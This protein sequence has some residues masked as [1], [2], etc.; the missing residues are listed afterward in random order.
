M[1]TS[2][3]SRAWIDDP[4]VSVS[5]DD[6]DGEAGVAAARAAAA[7]RSSVAICDV[8]AHSD[9]VGWGARFVR[10]S[11]CRIGPSGW[12]GLGVGGQR[13]TPRIEVRPHTGARWDVRR[14]QRPPA[15]GRGPRCRTARQRAGR[16]P[17]G[18][19]PGSQR[20]GPRRTGRRTPPARR[21]PDSGGDAQRQW[22]LRGTRN[23]GR[24]RAWNARLPRGRDVRARRSCRRAVGCRRERCVLPGWRHHGARR[25][26]PGCDQ[27]Q[28]HSGAPCCNHNPTR[29]HPQRWLRLLRPVTT[30]SLL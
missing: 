7:G 2:S 25:P 4:T 24:L 12:V 16:S 18:R 9:G 8:A 28:P 15:A 1:T 5:V 22:R 11:N 26:L 17:R 10:S 20:T 3:I 6:G 27:R 30:L 21:R 19:S 14:R 23:V 13:Q 29:P